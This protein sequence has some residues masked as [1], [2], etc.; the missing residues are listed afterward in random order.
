MQVIKIHS[1]YSL[2]SFYYKFWFM[3]K[4]KPTPFFWFNPHDMPLGELVRFKFFCSKIYKT[5]AYRYYSAIY[6]VDL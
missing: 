4:F 6:K 5:L 1:R 3:K 2:V